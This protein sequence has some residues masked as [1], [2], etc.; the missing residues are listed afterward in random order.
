MDIKLLPCPFCGGEAKVS[1]NNMMIKGN[2]E[3][4][5]WVYCKKCGARTHYER[6]SKRE[7]YVRDAVN[8]WNARCKK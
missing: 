3:M 8:A 7:H 1:S 4:C 6:R 2:S 5:A